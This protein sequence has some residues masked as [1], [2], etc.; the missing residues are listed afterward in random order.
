MY[1]SYRNTMNISP[2]ETAVLILKTSDIS[3]NYTL[4]SYQERFVNEVGTIERYSTSTTW[5]INVEELMGSMFN[6]YDN[7]SLKLVDIQ[8]VPLSNNVGD[9]T[10]PLNSHLYTEFQALSLYCDGLD[11][12]NSTYDQATNS[13]RGYIQL[14]SISNQYYYYNSAIMFPGNLRNNKYLFRENPN[15]G[16]PEHIFR[17]QSRASIR[18]WYSALSSNALNIPESIF[19][20]IDYATSPLFSQMQD[21]IMR[22]EISPA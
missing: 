12:T 8:T 17:K 19:T 2:K 20:G 18:V 4:N 1:P 22:F 21:V 10:R 16:E 13:G 9:W 7:F 14:G 3:P 5:N 15:G 11:F 6:K